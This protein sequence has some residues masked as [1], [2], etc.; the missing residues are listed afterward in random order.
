M[1]EQR[2]ATWIST[3]IEDGNSAIEETAILDFYGSFGVGEKAPLLPVTRYISATYVT[4]PDPC[5]E[6]SFIADCPCI[7]SLEDAK[8]KLEEEQR[9]H[10]IHLQEPQ[11]RMAQNR[12]N[13]YKRRWKKSF[14]L[15]T[16]EDY[17][18]L[19]HEVRN[20]R[21]G[22]KYLSE[23]RQRR[24]YDQPDMRRCMNNNYN[25]MK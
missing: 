18:I 15:E 23:G 22:L 6:H 2:A 12:T 10:W 9:M 5:Q 20:Q 21:K 1:N 17:H 7:M 8:S 24:S 13:Q 3:G 16:A 14:H 25:S 19:A 4:N 11:R